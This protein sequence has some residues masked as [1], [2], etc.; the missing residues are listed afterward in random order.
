[1]PLIQVPPPVSEPLT[2]A[3]ARAHLRV[4]DVGDDSLIAA[5]ISTARQLAEDRTGRSLGTQ[6]WELS[7]PRFPDGNAPID[8]PR[9][10]FVSVTSVT[11]TN[12]AGASI[13]MPAQDYTVTPGIV[14]SQLRPAP[15][16]VKVW[17][18]TYDQADAV[19]IRYVAGYSQIPTPILS[20]M[21]LTIGTLYDHREMV[22][23]GETATASF[24]PRSVA[25]GLLDAY[26]VRVV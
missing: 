18:D 20:W 13:V 4:D 23:R 6:S 9:P 1:M 16:Q 25:D 24:L 15:A 8:L 10:P 3:Q 19:R 11:Y 26:V 12:A 21:L 14:L 22:L 5:L 2:I 17:P 7:L